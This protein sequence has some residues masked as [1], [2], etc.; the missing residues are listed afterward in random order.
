[1]TEL[2]GDRV[3]LPALTAAQETAGRLPH[4]MAGYIAWLAPQMSMLPQLLADRFAALRGRVTAGNAHRRIPEAIAHLYLGIDMGL[5]YATECGACGDQEAADLR[6]EA[7]KTLLE[8]STT[9]GALILGERPTH[10]FLYVLLNLIV[11]RK[12]VL[13]DRDAGDHPGHPELLGWQ[14]SDFLDLLPEAAWHAVTSFCKD[15]GALF[16]IREE[17]LRRDLKKEGLAEPDPGRFTATVRIAGHTRRVLRLHR[18]MVEEIV[19]ET[20]PSPPITGITG[21]GR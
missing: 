11:Q 15:T 12:G 20:F 3:N 14:D 17:R 7:W 6:G 18:E 9:Q 10:R 8:I 19:G 16:P 21:D 1:M 2:D 13:L 5:T 4:A